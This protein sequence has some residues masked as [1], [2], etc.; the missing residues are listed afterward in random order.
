MGRAFDQASTDIAGNSGSNPHRI[1][2]ARLQL[3]GAALSVANDDS[4]DA[5]AIRNAAMRAMAQKFK[6][7]PSASDSRSAHRS[8][9]R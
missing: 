1:Q 2:A 3:A 9:A 7:L 8:G 4:R 6:T 5:G